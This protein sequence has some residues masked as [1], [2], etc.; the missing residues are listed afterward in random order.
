VQ[1][2]GIMEAIN[3]LNEALSQI[4]NVM[5]F[6]HD[7]KLGYVSAFTKYMNEFTINIRLRVHEKMEIDKDSKTGMACV[8]SDF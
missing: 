6:A 8:L 2:M 7:Y 4:E 3:Q 1:D 5:N